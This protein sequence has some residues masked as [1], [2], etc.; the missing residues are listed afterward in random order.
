ML[1]RK[2]VVRACMVV[3]GILA[4]SLLDPRLPAVGPG[5]VHGQAPSSQVY[6]PAHPT[7]LEALREFLNRRSQAVQPIAYTHQVHLANGIITYEL[8]M[9]GAIL[10]T[11]VTLLVG[12]RLPSWF[13]HLYD[14]EISAGK[15]L[16]GVVNPP[17]ESRAVLEKRLRDAGAAEVREFSKSSRRN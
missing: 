8:M 1:G 12:A 14:P 3:V 7:V 15:I 17:P 6:T 10:A 2:V 4:V 11:L 16:I 9:L 5:A 13:K